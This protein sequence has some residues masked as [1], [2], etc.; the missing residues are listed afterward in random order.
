MEIL[1]SRT[2]NRYEKVVTVFIGSSKDAPNRKYQ[3]ILA[4]DPEIVP[5]VLT[6]PFVH[7]EA[8]DPDNDEETARSMISYLAPE[9][10]HEDL[11]YRTTRIREFL[12]VKIISR[13]RYY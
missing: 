1:Y 6:I 3:E 7:Q 11:F 2:E 8:D 9:Y 12:L 13:F 10:V 5:P 4:M